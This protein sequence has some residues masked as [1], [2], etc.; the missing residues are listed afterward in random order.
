[1][2]DLAHT[3]G[4]RR[5]NLAQR[6][7]ALVGQKTLKEDLQPDRFQKA[8]AGV[9]SKLPIAF[10]FTGQGAQWPQM[11]KELLEEFPCFRRSIQELDAVLQKLPEK[12]EW[13]IQQALMDPEQSSQINHVTRS[14]PVCTAVQVALVQLLTQ[15]GIKPCGVIGHSSGEICA[16]F[17]AGRLTAPQAIIVAYYR[18][19]VVGKSETKTSGA[20]MAAALSKDDANSEI[21]LLG[22][23]ECIQVACVN[24]PESVTVSGDASGIERLLA[25]L[26]ARGIFARKLNTDGRAYHSRHMMALGEEYQDLLEKRI[27]GLPIRHGSSRTTWVS[28]VYAK[29]VS[30]KILPAYWRKNLESPVLFSDALKRLLKDSKLH[31]IEI[32]PHSALEMPIKQT[33]KS[34]KIGEAGFHYSSAL[35]RGK[36]SLHCVLSLMGNLFLH[37]HEISFAKVNQ[38]DISTSTSAQGKV[39]SNLPPYPWTY[40][41][42]LFNESRSSRELRNRRYGHHDLLGIQSVGGNGLAT[43]WRNTLRV[44]DIPWV[45]SHKLGQ[46]VVFPG[47]GYIAMAIEAISQVTGN[48]KADAPSFSL[49]HVNIIK[50]L[51]LSADEANPGVEIFTSLVPMKISGTTYSTNWFEFEITSYENEKSATHATGMISLETSTEPISPK[52]SSK[53]V[54][55]QESAIRNWYDRFTA[56]GL[57]FGPAFQNLET[58]ATDRRKE[59]MFACSTVRYLRGGGTGAQTQADYIMHPITIDSMLQTALIASSAGAMSKLS[60]MV[61]TTIEQ[62]RFRL[63]TLPVEESPWFVDAIS[64]P[65]GPGSIQAVTEIHDR[66]GNVCAQLENVRAT[67]FQGFKEDVSSIASRHPMMKVIW[68][69]DITKLTSDNAPAFGSYLA[70]STRNL[71]KS[72]LSDSVLKLGAMADIVCHKTPRINILELGTPAAKFTKHL[73]GLLRSETSFKRFGSY[74]RGYFSENAEL[75]VEAVDSV[76]S[77]GDTFEKIHPQRDTTYDLILFPNSLSAGEYT[78]KRLDF[79]KSLLSPQGIMLGLLPAALEAQHV[80]ASVGLSTIEIP[81]ENVSERV[82]FGRFADR[83]QDKLTHQNHIILVER[84]DTHTFNNLLFLKLSEHFDQDVERFTLAKL[85]PNVI[86]QDTTIVCTIELNQSILATLSAAEMI[87]VKTMTDNATKILWVTAGGQIDALR[88]NFAMVSGFSRSLVL[89]QPSL[90]FFTFDIDDPKANQEMSIQNII[91]TMNDIHSDDIPDSETVQ[92]NGIA[93]ISRF[94]PEETM[95]ETFRQNQGGTA[96][97][98]PLGE[99]KPSRL[100]IQ[101][102]GQFDTLAFKQDAPDSSELMTDFVEV[103]VKSVGLNAKVYDIEVV[104]SVLTSLLTFPRMSLFTAGK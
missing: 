40:D 67:A 89:E 93:H 101:S 11:G 57:N 82:I 31:L 94:V 92:K 91:A 68:K 1:M 58:I 76:D 102:L 18:G 47:A 52:V 10:I 56:V 33:C 22:L 24:S 49:R 26:K 88:P 20:M 98:R 65:I 83:N 61:P 42:I 74:S 81:I 30:D 23:S 64:E 66:Q 16:A 62:A 78:S 7:F 36:N 70:K 25:E 29:P 59:L 15:W 34:L 53:K 60:C 104:I 84:D 50:V 2:V 96:M 71:S 73:L 19:Y 32:G 75:F 51:P 103:E 41:Q 14:Q 3:L 79:V 99:T 100:T 12:P 39:L 63:P 77:V 72:A 54:D 28:S 48:V 90:K 80:A 87:S 46:D 8:V 55:F 45:A 85:T 5:S 9:Y 6:G 69:P 37:G 95:N 4:T 13:T 27:G 86:T 21:E 17:A 44:K 35:S 38:V 43:T 97:L